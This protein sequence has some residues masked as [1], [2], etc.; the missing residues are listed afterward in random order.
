MPDNNEPTLG[1]VIAALTGLEDDVIAALTGLEDR[2]GR[3]LEVIDLELRA[4][5]AQMTLLEASFSA[6]LADHIQRGHRGDGV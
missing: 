1:D 6:A 4:M 2:I 3:R 5:R